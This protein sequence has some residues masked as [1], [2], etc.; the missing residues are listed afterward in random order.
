VVKA[1]GGLVVKSP[2]GGIGQG[3]GSAEAVEDARL[4]CGSDEED[5]ILSVVDD[6]IHFENAYYGDWS[7]FTVD[8]GACRRP[9]DTFRNKPRDNRM[10]GHRSHEDG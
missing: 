4:C 8:E 2:E 1:V 6:M 10:H 5:V 7:V 9:N 3:G